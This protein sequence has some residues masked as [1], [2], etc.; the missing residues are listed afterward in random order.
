M[1]NTI[2][3]ILLLSSLTSLFAANSVVQICNQNAD[4]KIYASHLRQVGGGAGW[5]SN[6][7]FPIEKSKCLDVNFGTYVGKAYLFAQ[8]EFNE[9]EWGEGSVQF[10]VNRTQAFSLNNADTIPCT[11]PTL[12]R[13][14]SDELSV[15]PGT[16]VWNVTPN[17]SQ[18]NFCNQ[19]S[20]FPVYASYAKK[21]GSGW[22]SAGWYA[23]EP[24]KCRVVTVGKYSGEAYYFGEYGALSWGEGPFS[25]C[26][27]K[28]QP[29]TISNAEQSALCTGESVKMAKA[30]RIEIVPG[31]NTVNFQEILA[32]S[33]IKLCNRTNNRTLEAMYAVAGEGQ[34]WRSKGWVEIAPGKCSE[35]DLGHYAGKGYVYAEW[36]KGEEFWGSGPVNLCVKRDENFTIEDS[37]NT[38]LCNSDIHNKM[39]PVYEENITFGTLQINFNP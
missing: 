36:N 32:K 16:T 2:L 1:K 24:Q 5:Q 23:V 37:G 8:D 17:F 35:V 3:S 34:K 7:W 6:G 33:I 19:N 26:V 21:S 13:V 9:S 4:R 14:K 12:K 27:N 11:D 25:Y 29:F 38:E 31:T 15:Q 30:N 22:Q 10:C 18:I 28:T 39:V 20:A